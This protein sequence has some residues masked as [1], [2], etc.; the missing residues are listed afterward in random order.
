MK[1][2][3]RFVVLLMGLSG[4]LF[5]WDKPTHSVSA[6]IAFNELQAQHPNVVK[7][8]IKVL[9]KSADYTA[10]T[11]WDEI[12]PEGSPFEDEVIFQ[13]AARWPDDIK[14]DETRRDVDPENT[15]PWHYVDFPAGPLAG[16]HRPL[17]ENLVTMMRKFRDEYPH[18]NDARKAELICWFMHL[19]GDSHQ[20]L[21]AATFY[22]KDF[23]AGDDG[24]VKWQIQKVGYATQLHAFWDQLV[25]NDKETHLPGPLAPI[26]RAKAIELA[27]AHPRSSFPQLGAD[28]DLEDWIRNETFVMAV[29]V[30]YQN[31]NLPAPRA[32]HPT[33]LTDEYIKTSTAAAEAQVVLAGYRISDF[34]QAL[35][36]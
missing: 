28:K 22:S 29:E 19:I 11:K 7:K 26:V 15:H 35:F 3:F 34:L 2:H 24:G 9:K 8:V 14:T 33:V 36:K 20:P 17:K 25:L 21:H 10:Y 18:T 32:K 23:Q 13:L 27:K 5:A 1:K 16:G 12:A 30:A 6:V 4:S 31:G